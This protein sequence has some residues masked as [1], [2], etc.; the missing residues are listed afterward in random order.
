MLQDVPEVLD[1]TEAVETN[2]GGLGL[3]ENTIQTYWL[4][5]DRCTNNNIF[6]N[7]SL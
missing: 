2:L 3:D 1:M 5:Y 7:S 6:P 4:S